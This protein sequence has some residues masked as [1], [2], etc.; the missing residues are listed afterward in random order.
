LPT[1]RLPQIC[2][3]RISGCQQRRLRLRIKLVQDASP[4]GRDR[5]KKAAL[6]VAHS[7]ETERAFFL[8]P[9]LQ[10]ANAE[11]TE[12][13]HFEPSSASRIAFECD[14]MVNF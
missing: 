5:L 12:P 8:A 1:G 2:F 11:E 9:V 4:N 13:H 6:S 7:D 14:L 3:R 10:E